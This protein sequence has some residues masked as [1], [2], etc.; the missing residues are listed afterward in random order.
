MGDYLARHEVASFPYQEWKPFPPEAIVQV[1][2]S[3]DG[4]PVIA[5]AKDLWW[6]WEDGLDGEES[7][8]RYARRLDTPKA[9]GTA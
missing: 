7:V 4:H 8:I 5:Q 1:K 3:F 9:K 6:G 2:S